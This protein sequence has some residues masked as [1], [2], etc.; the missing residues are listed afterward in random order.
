MNYTKYGGALILGFQ[1]LVIKVHGR[2][3]AKAIKNAILFAEKSIKNE[4]VKH[5][6]QSMKNFYINLFNHNNEMKS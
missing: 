5:I 6:E 4:L 2:S 3:K 1:K